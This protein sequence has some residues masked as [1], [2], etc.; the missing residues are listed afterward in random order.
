MRWIVG[1]LLVAAALL[2]GLDLILHPASVLANDTSQ[3]LVPLLVGCELA[4]G[5]LAIAD[6]Y[7]SRLRLLAILL[8][9]S[10]ASYSLWLALHGAAS[11]G[12]F[13]PLEIHPWWTFLLDCIV[14]AGLMGEY[15]WVGREEKNDSSSPTL[16]TTSL[17]LV[18]ILLLPLGITAAL[19]WQVAPTPNSS[20]QPFQT[21]GDIVLLEP[22]TWL[23]QKFPLL[24][25]INLDLSEGNW[26]ILLHR[27]D[28]P[29]CQEAVLK[30]EQ[31]ASIKSPSQIAI[32]EVPPYGRHQDPHIGDLHV[33]SLNDDHDWFIQT[34]I[35]IQLAGGLVVAAYQELPSIY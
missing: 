29:K 19:A 15:L 22:E 32:V 21:V 18:S 14:L 28:C 3:F 30:Y 35:E 6:I 5:L 12:C 27:H 7:W 4:L 2:K 17:S 31:L 26:I 34:P 16:A 1:L 25:Y 8:F 9:A 20:Q 33:G 10:F 23:G 24:E 13:G 11:C